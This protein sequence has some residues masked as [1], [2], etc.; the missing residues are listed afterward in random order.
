MHNTG[1]SHI[2][3][4]FHLGRVT[5]QSSMQVSSSQHSRYDG[6]TPD[7][8]L[9]QEIDHFHQYMRSLLDKDLLA[10]SE[11][12]YRALDKFILELKHSQQPTVSDSLFVSNRHD[13]KNGNVHLNGLVQNSVA[14]AY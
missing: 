5:G 9:N 13:G 11:E 2:R 8:Q 3:T 7:H 12:K 14:T 10:V 1:T 4:D 6:T